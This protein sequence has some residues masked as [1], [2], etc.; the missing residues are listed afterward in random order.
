MPRHHGGRRQVPVP[1][2]DTYNFF[3]PNDDCGKYVTA[4]YRSQP[5]YTK[6][7]CDTFV[8]NINENYVLNPWII[9]AP[10]IGFVVIFFGAIFAGFLIMI[11]FALAFG[12]MFLLIG[13]SC[14]K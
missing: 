1:P 5:H 7:E 10:M 4:L 11:G 13:C 6:E 12:G 8:K 3:F 2:S 14:H 9:L